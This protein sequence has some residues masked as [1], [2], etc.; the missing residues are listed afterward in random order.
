MASSELIADYRRWLTFQ[1]QEQLS[2]EHSGIVQ[3]L[4]DAHASSRQVMQA[5]RSMAEKAAAEGACYR[6]LFL[7][8]RENNE[9]LV[10][11]GWLFIRR[12]LSEGEQARVRA[13]LLETF[14][15]EDGIIAPGDKPARKVTLEIF[16]R[17]HMDK[18]MRTSVQVDCVDTE[19]DYHFITLLDAVRGDLRPHLK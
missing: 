7:R 16:D 1:H 13:T 2:R 12:L 18:G 6:T 10:C 3:R 8:T 4:E 5:Y 19:H 9:A 11:E 17:V 14:T 15:L